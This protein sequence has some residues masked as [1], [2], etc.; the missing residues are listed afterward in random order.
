MQLKVAMK[1][2]YKATIIA[3]VSLDTTESY[4]GF[5]IG[6]VDTQLELHLSQ[7]CEQC[8]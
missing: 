6:C 1:V 7:C 5:I 4:I 8:S 3:R 2:V